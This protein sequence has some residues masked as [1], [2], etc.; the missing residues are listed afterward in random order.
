[1]AAFEVADLA[2]CR[3]RLVSRGF[4]PTEIAEG[5]LPNS[6]TVVVGADQLSGF[7]LQLISFG[8]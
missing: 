2:A 7:T 5:A 8:G 4:E 3:S 1:M 6:E